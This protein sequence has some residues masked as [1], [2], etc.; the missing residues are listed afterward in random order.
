MSEKGA[1]PTVGKQYS[2]TN[3]TRAVTLADNGSIAD[4][5][6]L[7]LKGLLGTKT[8]PP[9]QGL[10]IQPCQSV[11]TFFMGYPIDILFLDKNHRVVD[12]Y[13]SLPPNRISRLVFKARLVI[14][15]PSGTLEQTGTEIGDLLAIEAAT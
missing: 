14:E 2:F 6:W 1:A 11:H 7:R 5:P 13:K 10:L 4:N 8:L 15:L 9:G 12:L 3:L